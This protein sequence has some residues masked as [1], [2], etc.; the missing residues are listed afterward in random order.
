MN[1]SDSRFEPI[2]EQFRSVG[3]DKIRELEAKLK[4]LLPKEYVTFLSRYGGCGFSG[5]AYATLGARKLPIFTFF[6]DQKILSKLEVFSDL[7]AE[8]KF[9]IAD[10]M[11]GNPYVL[12]ALTG[13][14]FF[15]DFSVNPPVGTKVAGSFDEFL[16]SIEVQ[17]F[18]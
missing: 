12:D 5:D 15:I 3:A 8:S 17:P 4:T 13:K 9:S 6:D 2:H 7:T 16:A 14:V 18:E 10:D 11:A 1:P